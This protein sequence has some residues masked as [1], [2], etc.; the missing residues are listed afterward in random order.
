MSSVRGFLSAAR[1]KPAIR[2]K[3]MRAAKN[4]FL[5]VTGHCTPVES[6]EKVGALPPVGLHPDVQIEVDL[7]AEK[8]LH[9]LASQGPDAFQHRSL[10][11]DH[12]SLLPVPLHMDGGVDAGQPLRLL[13]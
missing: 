11:A 13:P 9:L 8:P 2:N 10:G 5:I 12:D 6:I 7:H 4:L 1:Q 3:A